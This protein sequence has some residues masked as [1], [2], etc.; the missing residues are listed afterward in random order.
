MRILTT[1]IEDITFADIVGFCQEKQIEG[2]ELD[3]KKDLSEK[4][5][6]K[7]IAAFSNTRGGIMIIGVEED[8]KTGVPLKWEGVDNDGKLIDRIH[9]YAA[10]VTPLPSYTVRVTDEVNGKVFLLLRIL[11][12]DS[13]P[14]YVRNRSDI[15]VRLGNISTQASPED[16]Q[17]LIGKKEQ[18][19]Q[20]RAFF[21]SRAEEV[22]LAALKRA[23]R[24]RRRLVAED[25]E[26]RR[27]EHELHG[28]DNLRNSNPRLYKS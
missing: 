4:G 15:W 24:E 19:A 16:L 22:S 27:K 17:R 14:Y 28:V 2:T 9:Q 11:E 10:N 1:P 23:E 18:A 3:Y 26:R 12:G 7:H 20:A 13:T 6:A 8:S 25:Q 5:L 21:I